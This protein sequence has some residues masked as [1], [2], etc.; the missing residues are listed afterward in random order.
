MSPPDVVVVGAGFAGLSAAVRLAS[1]GARVAVVE[2]R[3][4]LGGRATSFQ[5]AATG[6]LVDNGQHAIFGCYHAT[7][8]FLGTIGALDD[9]RVDD[10]LEIEIVDRAGLDSCLRSTVLPPPL[11]LVGGLLRWP[12]LGLADR[13]SALRLGAALRGPRDNAALSR[14]TVNEW[15][16]A[17]RQTERLREVLWQPLAV[18]ALNQSPAVAS[19]VTFVECLT[20]MFKGTRRDSAVGLPLKPLDRWFAEPARDWLVANGHQFLAGQPARLLLDGTRAIGVDVRG[21]RL[22]AGAVVSAVPWFAFPA[23]AE[24]VSAVKHIADHAAAMT[25]SPIVTVNLWLDRPVTR[26]AFVGLPGRTFQWIFDKSRLAGSAWSHLSLVS[27]GADDVVAQS[28]EALIDLATRELK[29]ALPA[30]ASASVRRASAVRE[31]RAT[32][33]LAPG[34][35]PRPQAETPLPGLVLA[36]DWTDTGLPATIEGAVVSGHRAADV[37]APR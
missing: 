20:R 28:N 13:L 6:E 21:E 2:E 10:R 3:R 12:A 33:S 14:M 9:V 23:F 8:E 36:G 35:P 30:A 1:R 5:D 27:S 19:A 29:A 15:L 7:F 26:T 24:G 25:P 17:H 37:L 11:H 32:F 34:Q 31:K 18:A 22:L 4:R 16:I